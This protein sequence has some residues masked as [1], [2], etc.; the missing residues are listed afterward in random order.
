ML[1]SDRVRLLNA[2]RRYEKDKCIELSWCMADEAKNSCRHELLAHRIS[3]C[4]SPPSDKWLVMTQATGADVLVWAGCY[5]LSCCCC[6]TV[7]GR[8][9]PRQATFFSCSCKQRRQ[10]NTPRMSASLRF[11]PGKPAS[12]YSV[13]GAAQLAARL[14]RSAQTNGGKSE[15]KALALFGA[16]ARSLNSVPQART[17]GWMRTACR[18]Y[19]EIGFWR[20]SGLR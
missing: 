5:L 13:C 10:K 20:I 15:H 11:A 9:S 12:R 1:L 14:C 2:A 4:W 6:I 17:H 19:D 18:S 7:R 16:N 8:V 3:N